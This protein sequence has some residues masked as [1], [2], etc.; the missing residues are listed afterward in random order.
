[1]KDPHL[2]SSGVWQL[3]LPSKLQKSSS[4][5]SLGQCRMFTVPCHKGLGFRAFVLGLGFRVWGLGLEV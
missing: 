3:S 4:I 5:S 2:N 1:M